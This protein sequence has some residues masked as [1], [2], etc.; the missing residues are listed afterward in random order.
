MSRRTGSSHRDR[1]RRE[2]RFLGRQFVG[3]LLFI[4][5]F[6]HFILQRNCI[7]CTYISFLSV[8][9]LNAFSEK[10]YGSLEFINIVY[11]HKRLRIFNEF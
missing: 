4:Y 5:G 3:G 8:F 11:F 9:F 2:P 7:F 1:F 10:I 6:V